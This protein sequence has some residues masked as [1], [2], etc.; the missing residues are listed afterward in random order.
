MGHE[1]VGTLPRTRA[2]RAIVR[3]L[4]AGSEVPGS[5][6]QIAKATLANVQQRFDRI[7]SDPGFQASFAFLLRLTLAE[8]SAAASESL[9]KIDL[10]ANPTTVRLTAMLRRWVDANAGSNEYAE[11]SKRAAA[12]AIDCWTKGQELQSE[13]FSAPGDTTAVWRAAQNAGAFS[14]ICRV[15]FGKFTERYIRYFLDRE[16]SAQ[17]P[18]VDARNQFSRNLEQHLE[19]IARHSF[20]TTKI[21]QSFSAGWY[22]RYARGVDAPDTATTQRFLGYAMAK[23]KSEL[24]RESSEA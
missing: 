18:T 1:R 22:N 8:H 16:A 12:D 14:D 20:E 23:L 15:F 5:V 6:D 7:H 11:L 19:Q 4:R 17:I 2:W 24:L 10:S 13:F 3:D 21:S 9:P